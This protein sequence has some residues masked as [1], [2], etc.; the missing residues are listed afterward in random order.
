MARIRT[1]QPDFAQARSMKRV[2]RDGRLLFI[3]LWTAA[4]DAGRLRADTPLLLALLYPADSDAAMLLP[5]WLDEL[6]REGCIRRY[7]VDG[8]QYA[9]IVNWRK[10]QTIDRA[11]PS[12]LPAPSGVAT[13]SRSRR[14][15]ASKS[16]EGEENPEQSRLGR[17]VFED[18]ETMVEAMIEGPSEVSE[19]TVMRALRRILATSEARGSFTPALR[20]VELMGRRIGLWTDRAAGKKD[21]VPD[22]TSPSLSELHRVSAS[23]G[24]EG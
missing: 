6:E 19:Q 18:G 13:A 21:A 24:A 9:V 10:Y 11:K 16:L 12:R 7:A 8:E 1:I 22:P 3:Q 23:T 5:A 15:D 20:C 17:E 14:D 2:S 4:D